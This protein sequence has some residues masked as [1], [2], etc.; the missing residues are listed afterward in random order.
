MPGR[1]FARTVAALRLRLGPPD[2][3]GCRFYR[4]YR[5][6]YGY[7]IIRCQGRRRP[8]SAV[9]CEAEHGPPP[10]GL[11]A[12]H[13]CHR[14]ACCESTHLYWG[15]HAQNMADMVASGRHVAFRAAGGLNSHAKLTAEQ[16][17]AIRQDWLVT[18][19][20][21]RKARAAEYGVHEHT[22]WEIAAGKTWRHLL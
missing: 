19:N 13:T 14:P 4:G 22:I 16:V 5:N 8:A 2:E 20:A 9:M 18:M 7:G 15:T 1:S 12:C 6:N 21:W 10:P 17:V 3:R 11:E